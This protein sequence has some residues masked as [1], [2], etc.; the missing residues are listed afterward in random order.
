[1]LWLSAILFFLLRLPS[2]FE[3]YWYGDEGVYLALGQ[4]IRHGLT[5]YSQIYDNKPPAIYYLAALTQTVF[6]F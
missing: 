6:G 5:L 4:G 2:L 3:P 1:M